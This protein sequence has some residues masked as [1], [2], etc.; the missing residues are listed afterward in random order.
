M[1]A[2]GRLAGSVAHDFNNMLVVIISCAQLA[3]EQIEES[4]AACGCTEDLEQ[5]LG[6]AQRAASLTQQLLAFSRQQVLEP[7]VV[8]LNE[9]VR[10]MGGLVSR[11]I[12]ENIR[13]TLRCS[14]RPARVVVDPSQIEQV[15]LNL[16]VNAR[17]AMPSGGQLEIATD[18]VSVPP[19]TALEEGLSSGDCF[20]LT[21]RDTGVGMS[22]ETLARIFEPFFTTK[23]G[24][25]G[26]GLGLA[27]VYGIVKERGGAMSVRS[28][29]GDGTLFRVLFPRATKDETVRAPTPTPFRANSGESVLLVED[30]EFVRKTAARVLARGGYTVLEAS[31]AE[32]ALV[33]LASA[34]VDLLLTD[35][36]MP[37]MSGAEL[38]RTARAR[39]PE[40]AVL[41]MSGY[42]DLPANA[43]L[44]PGQRLLAKPFTPS[45]LLGAVRE[46]IDAGREGMPAG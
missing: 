34:H 37:G 28:A 33:S 15:V 7:R 41:V 32:D 3:L 29:E 39:F 9:V 20:A 26:T 6:A 23:E 46:S 2:I 38:A 35:V 44:E 36:V 11:L 1:D 31:N 25:E 5:I 12:G 17:D 18:A 45:T 10:D 4:G 27:T 21:V 24:G 14:E 8:D 19:A 13:C 42:L 43:S 30:D 16:V 22:A 40:L